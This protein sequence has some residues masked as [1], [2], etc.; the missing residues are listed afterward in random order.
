[1]MA[2]VALRSA[3]LGRVVLSGRGA[4]RGR[5]LPWFPPKNV[6][7]LGEVL[8]LAAWRAFGPPPFPPS[9][10][11][12][13]VFFAR[14]LGPRDAP[15][16]PRFFGGKGQ[17]GSSPSNPCIRRPS[18]IDNGSRED[19][20]VVPSRVNGGKKKC[21]W[22]GGGRRC[23]LTKAA[24]FR[25]PIVSFTSRCVCDKKEISAY[26]TTRGFS[27]KREHSKNK[28]NEKNNARCYILIRPA[29]EGLGEM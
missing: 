26:D 9:L 21:T 2:A 7:R 24:R 19:T 17:P 16:A 13:A 11:I 23:C 27:F 6:R 22:F 5:G 4:R 14:F 25:V 10:C 1:M 18:F 28:G 15:S 12:R 20:A 29:A 3:A 8:D